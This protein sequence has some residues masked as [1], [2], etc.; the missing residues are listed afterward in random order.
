VA[1]FKPSGTKLN[2]DT[3]KSNQHSTKQCRSFRTS[4]KA[5]KKD[6]FDADVDPIPSDLTEFLRHKKF[7]QRDEFRTGARGAELI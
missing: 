5:E 3:K 4:K 6:N 7:D 2:S 1:S